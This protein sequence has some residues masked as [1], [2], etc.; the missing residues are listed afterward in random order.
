MSLTPGARIGP[1]EIT[2]QIGAGG[3]GQV[4]R[5]TDTTLG[6][7][8]AI[9]ILPDAFASDPERLARFGR[10][11]TTLA[12]LNHPNIAAIFG[13]EKSAGLQA[14]IMEL[15][16]GEDL[17]TMIARG[18]VSPS[19]TLSIA[20]QIADA[21]EVA[22]EQGIIHRD[23]KP[24]NI[25][26]RADGTVKVL[27]FGL[28]KALAPEGASATA[29][30]AN[31]P[32]ITSPAMTEMGIV[33]GTAAYMSPEQ[34]RGRPVDR[35]ADIWA[36]GVVLYEMS[37]G[38]RL[39]GG[40][41]VTETIA[42]VVKDE[43]NLAAAPPALRRLLG[44]CLE[45]DPRKRLRDISVAW[46]LI[47]GPGGP[48]TAGDR[49]PSRPRRWWLPWAVVSA[50]LAA[51]AAFAVLWLNVPQ[52]DVRSV[53]F[54]VGP[55]AETVLTNPYGA[56]AVSP[57]GR[58][59]VFAAGSVATNSSSLWLRQMDSRSARQL[60]GT[61]G[62]NFPFW[63]P[64]SQWVAFYQAGK[65][66]RTGIVGGAPQVLCDAAN[67]AGS[68]GTWNRDDT[69]LFAS[70]GGLFRVGG[71]GG[72]PERVT[73][74]DAARQE[75]G[76]GHPQ[77]LPDGRHFLY[78]IS[79][80]DPTVEGIYAGS[81]DDPTVRVRIV[82]AERKAS[83]VTSRD[84]RTGY[85]LW[86]RDEMLVAQ[87]FDPGTL[88]LSGTPLPIVDDIAAGGPATRAA[89]WTSQSGVLA[90]RT[91]A[92]ARA[93]LVWM[94]RSGQLLG[95]AA[96][97][98]LRGSF[99][100]SRDGSRVAMGIADDSGN[101][102]I[103]TLDLARQVTTRVTFDPAGE[104]IPVWSHDDSRIA[105]VSDRS[106]IRQIYRTAFGGGGTEEQLTTEPSWKSILDWSPDGRHLLYLRASGTTGSDIWVSPLEGERTPAVV[107]QT[108]FS[109]NGA[110]FSPDGKWIAYASN[111]T[112]RLE[113]YVRP[114]PPASE[115]PWQV[116]NQGGS[117]PKWGD[118][119]KALYFLGPS[120]GQQTPLM[121]ADVRV[122]GG[123]LE[124]DAPRELFRIG[125]VS[126]S[127][128]SPY[129]VTRDGQRFL[130]YQPSSAAASTAPPLTVVTDWRV[131]LTR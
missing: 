52:P 63:S 77:F 43:P 62:A 13:F 110:R 95:E 24:A 6:R 67:L 10:E 53:E 39:F 11:A 72:V 4:W 121:A 21:L 120:A 15:V 68:G 84:G 104:V 34:A 71:S 82:A 123:R 41:D 37:V 69:V 114:F 64:D 45:K 60:Q 97:E 27:D 101:A 16:E 88:T 103:W 98:A 25:K 92:T 116:S 86:L 35:R 131:R 28:A 80:D 48:A 111:A 76:Y 108:P 99:K 117:R 18:P 17:S 124:T 36:F 126:P 33:L 90:Y 50:A 51:A 112:G 78:F 89:F 5:A 44:R 94:S 57:D 59:L 118:D 8:V 49:E 30:L 61:E 81:L 65:L 14:L 129:D 70:T 119:G 109:E 93:S 23:L 87:P 96:P 54:N 100:L 115:S 20:R 22:H 56:T 127:V 66:K 40:D 9:K 3:M 105:Y 73:T 38:R 46:E 29:D 42:S 91:E 32:T 19:D 85:L 26:V 107:V 58:Y 7:Q 1:Y 113:V 128:Y 106:G 130:I 47:D 122:L 125:T 102:D 79:S 12:S 2:A 75:R 31:S 55:P 74:A 83:Y